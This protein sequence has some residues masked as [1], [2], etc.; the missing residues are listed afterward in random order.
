MII[1]FFL[2]ILVAVLTFFLS[3]LPV[4]PIPQGWLDAVTLIWGY[5]NSMSFLLPI[6]TLLQIL[7]MVIVIEVAV[8]LWHMSLKIYHL[9]RR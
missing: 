9:I 8:F 3:I 1:G 4:I 6:A 7:S 5:I 2:T